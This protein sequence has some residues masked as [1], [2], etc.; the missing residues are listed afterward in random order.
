MRRDDRSEKSTLIPV[1]RT[2]LTR[3]NPRMPKKQTI[4]TD[5]ERT[6]RIEETA[7][8]VDADDSIEVF[9]RVFK[10]VVLPAKKATP[11]S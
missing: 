10:K 1:P 5:E 6:R 3:Y 11:A 8:E 9:D 4:L 7:R 2:N